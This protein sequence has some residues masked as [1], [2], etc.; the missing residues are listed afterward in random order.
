M[1]YLILLELFKLSDLQN[2]SFK[3]SAN[4]N[5]ISDQNSINEKVNAFVFEEN[6]NS[7]TFLHYTKNKWD[8]DQILKEGFKYSES[9]YKTAEL[10]DNDW[11]YNSY[12]HYLQ[13]S[14]GKNIMIIKIPEILY[15]T[16]IN[17]YKELKLN[18]FPP[19]ENLVS[20]KLFNQEDTEY[21][22]T[23]IL[24][25]RFVKGYINYP[26]NKLIKNK[27]YDPNINK[28]KILQLVLNQLD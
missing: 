26:N 18:K 8:A 12:N 10:V 14:F 17:I 15:S 27:A 6:E 16:A 9:F 7:K 13:K 3:V 4:K 24:N 20:E 25:I 1:T 5:N 21:E 28:G 19:I 23:H 22:L 2:S 11:N